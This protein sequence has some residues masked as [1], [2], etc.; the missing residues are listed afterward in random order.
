MIDKLSLT[1][2]VP[3]DREYL[4]GHGVLTEDA[5]RAQLYRYMCILDKA[6]VFFAPTNTGKAE[7]PGS[8]L[9]RSM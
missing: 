2:G 4:E 6:Q 7:T 5:Y 3:A 8:L 9:Q 1:I